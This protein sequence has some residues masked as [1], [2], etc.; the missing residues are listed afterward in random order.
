MDFSRRKAEVGDTC[1]VSAFG[2]VSCGNGRAIKVIPPLN[3]IIVGRDPLILGLA[4]T[5]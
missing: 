4:E 3:Q 2:R 5:A 1:I